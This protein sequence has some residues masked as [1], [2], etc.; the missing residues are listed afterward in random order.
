ML[1]LG[2]LGTLPAFLS[3]FLARRLCGGKAWRRGRGSRFKKQNQWLC[4][5]QVVTEPI[6]L[7]FSLDF[8]LIFSHHRN[9]YPGGGGDFEDYVRYIPDQAQIGEAFQVR[10]HDDGVAGHEF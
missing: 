1:K 7:L 6:R 9:R 5:R 8:Q 10:R 4:G 2:K 3:C